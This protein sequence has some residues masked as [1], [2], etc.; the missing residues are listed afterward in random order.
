[1]ADVMID[2]DVSD[3]RGTQQTLSKVE[4]EFAYRTSIF[5]RERKGDIV[6]AARFRVGRDDPGSI[7][8][9]T[10]AINQQRKETQPYG[11]RSLG[12]TFKN[13]EGD[14]AGRLIEAS[15]LKGKRIGGA[16]ISPKHANFI[17]N[18]DSA[19]AVDVIAL[20]ELAH[21]TVL[22]KFGVDLQPEIVVMGEDRQS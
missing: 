13:P 6:L 7:R 5:K 8:A 11:I 17:T 16:E 15:G 1:M 12:S 14:F 18:V 3:A 9:R 21:D 2:C 20:V 19:K 22:D 10:D 4:C